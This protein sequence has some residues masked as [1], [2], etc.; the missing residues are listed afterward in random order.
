MA[1]TFKQSAYLVPDGGLENLDLI[2]AFD[3][4]IALYTDLV[5]AL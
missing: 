1:Y 4:K 5:E 3:L 2:E